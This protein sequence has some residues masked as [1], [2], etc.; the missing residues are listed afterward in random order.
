MARLQGLFTENPDEMFGVRAWLVPALGL[1]VGALGGTLQ[2]RFLQAPLLRCFLL[3]AAFGLVFSVFFGKRSATPGA[4]LIWGLASGL[5]LWFV[6]LAAMDLFRSGS[7]LPP[8]MMSD[9][10]QQFPE[11]VSYLICLGMPVGV[12]LG[13][14][15]SLRQKSAEPRFHW[16]RAIVAG[17][18][19]GTIAGLAFSGW[20]YAG[21]YLPLLAG[22]P[23]FSTQRRAVLFHFVVALLIGAI[24]GILFQRDVR[25]YGSSMGWGVGFGIF[26]WF[27]GPLTAFPLITGQ[28]VDWSA[29]QGATLFGALIGYTI[30]G[31]ILGTIYAFLDRIWVRLFIQSD[32]LNREPE[33]A[34]L[35]FLRSLQWGSFAGLVGGLVSAPVMIATGILPKIAGLDSSFGGMRGLII[36]LLV[37]TGIGMTY[38]LLFRD[39]AP[40]VGLGIPWGFLFGLLW[41][42]V[43]PLTLLP[44][45]LTGV[46]DW[47][48]TAA[49]ALLP[50]LIGHLIYGGSTACAFL[51]LER[52]YKRW[53]LLDPRLAARELR[54]VRPAGTP[55]PALWF[56]A[57]G[58]GVLL[59]ILLG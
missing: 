39:E 30:Y 44:L 23:D 56:F 10:Q 32:P 20:E 17:G 45:T 18:F 42:Y 26:L 9:A 31:F 34:G 19:A 52:R 40:S 50:S 51:L 43:G 16:G 36:H 48:A 13:I 27:A 29:D 49:S 59:P 46:Y 15:R 25:G 8:D 54:R 4:G 12:A 24:F 3:G 38:G 11:L 37:S 55:A 22:L 1:A 47:R 2:S 14:L 57:L 53:L 33:G 35:H 6:R 58:L 7:A 5:L 21:G 41:W 28:P